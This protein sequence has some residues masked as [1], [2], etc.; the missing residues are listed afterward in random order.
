MNRRA[1]G[2]GNS[3]CRWAGILIVADHR[4]QR[5]LGDWLL[6]RPRDPFGPV[7]PERKLVHHVWCAFRE[8]DNPLVAGDPG[9]SSYP[10]A[11]S[12]ISHS[13]DEPLAIKK[14]R[15]GGVRLARVQAVHFGQ[16]RKARS[17][18]EE[19]RGESQSMGR[20]DSGHLAEII[21]GLTHRQVREDRT[22]NDQGKLPVI[23][24]ER[25]GETQTVPGAYEGE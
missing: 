11:E 4:W 22:R 14:D 9:R 18:E 13:S 23:H 12:Q 21:L 16:E 17:I 8:E 5:R 2:G 15:L 1:R 24:W 10:D 20:E 25:L 3:N 6:A 7:L 19:P